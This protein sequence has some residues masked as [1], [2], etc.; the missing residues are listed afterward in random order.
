MCPD[1]TVTHVP[2]SDRSARANYTSGAPTFVT[3]GGKSHASQGSVHDPPGEFSDDPQHFLL[4][5]RERSRS[6][7]CGSTVDQSRENRLLSVPESEPADLHTGRTR[8]AGPVGVAARQGVHVGKTNNPVSGLRPTPIQCPA[9]QD[10]HRKPDRIVDRL[11]GCHQAGQ[12]LE[13]FENGDTHDIVKICPANPPATNSAETV[14]QIVWA[15]PEVGARRSV[16]GGRCSVLGLRP[17][18][19][20]QPPFLGDS[21]RPGAGTLSTPWSRPRW[22]RAALQVQRV[23]RARTVTRTSRSAPLPSSTKAPTTSTSLPAIV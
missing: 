5:N 10:P 21:I 13:G 2:G 19:A 14:E 18:V 7:L 6:I 15:N 11:A 22:R 4:R 3:F 12:C 9:V 20:S 1:R 17:G 16:L 23:E 8:T